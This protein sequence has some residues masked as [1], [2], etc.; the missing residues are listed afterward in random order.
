LSGILSFLL[1]S[2]SANAQNFGSFEIK[3]KSGDPIPG[4][5]QV[6]RLN[7]LSRPDISQGGTLAFFAET[8]Q[9]TSITALYS[10]SGPAQSA[11]GR[12]IA[13]QQATPSS[14]GRVRSIDRVFRLDDGTLL[15]QVFL[16]NVTAAGNRAL[17]RTDA[18]QSITELLRE[19][20]PFAPGLPT[21]CRING[22]F[23]GVHVERN[24]D[25]WFAPLTTTTT[26]GSGCTRRSIYRLSATGVATTIISLGAPVSGTAATLSDIWGEIRG[27]DVGQIL[28]RGRD[29]ASSSSFWYLLRG[30]SVLRIA[31]AVNGDVYAGANETLSIVSSAAAT[32]FRGGSMSG[33]DVLR[34]GQN[35]PQGQGQFFSIRDAD[36][37]ADNV[38]VATMELTGTAGGNSDDSGIYLVDSQGVV[39]IA[40]EGMPAIAANSTFRSFPDFT[41]FAKVGPGGRVLFEA[42]YQVGGNSVRG[43]FYYDRISGLREILNNST[44]IQGLQVRDWTVGP[45]FNQRG[46]LPMRLTLSDNINYMVI[47]RLP[48]ATAAPPAA[49]AIIP[50]ITGAWYDP[51]QSGHGL[52]L[53][54]LAGNRLLAWWFT[55]DA[56]GNQAW[57][58]G[59]GTYVGDVATIPFTRT[60]GGRFIPN[61]NAAQV[62]NPAWG[63]A[64]IRFSSCGRGRIDYVSNSP[65]FGSGG[66]DLTRLTQPL[67]LTC[68][69]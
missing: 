24:G 1:A 64:T 45:R 53:E 32:Q 17:Y 31:A 69:L 43:W 67:G 27:N 56:E 34:R 7:T 37:A 10:L 46:E 62:S 47:Y 6:L 16:E 21:L 30:G 11:L 13:E 33:I 19:G 22:L 42:R 52:F 63:T 39:E 12:H 59:V 8:Q 50:G 66:M 5:T 25:V 20:K 54:V 23:E 29:T 9:S 49:F 40:R 4:S 48:G 55:F 65:G 60:T 38:I 36:V 61:F 35:L 15:A 26:A 68:P 51:Q 44:V 28:F 18:S 41:E 57:F 14:D 2:T 58:G 3:A